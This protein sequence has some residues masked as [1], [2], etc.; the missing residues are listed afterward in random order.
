MEQESRDDCVPTGSYARIYIKDVPLDVAS[1]LC[2]VSR[3]CPIV[4][5]G[6]L[7][8]EC[9]MSVLHFSIKKHD[10]YDAPI[11][12]KEEFIFHVGFRQFVARPIF[13][14]YNMN[15]DKHKV[16]RFLHAGRF[17]I[18]SIYALVS[19]PPL[20]LIVLKGAGG[21]S[22]PLAAA[23]GSLRSIDTDGIIL[24]KII[25]TGPWKLG[26]SVVAVVE[27]KS[28]LVHMKWFLRF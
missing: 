7:Q 23:V 6:L 8:H 27:L 2:V 26:Q 14:T 12:A 28:L 24:K 15:S 10:S 13:S 5:C 9:K 18:A 16:E 11:K 17:S 1:K 19:F 22:A 21:S 20:P 3:T 25:L 4:L